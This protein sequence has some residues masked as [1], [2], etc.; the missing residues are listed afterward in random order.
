VKI[1]TRLALALA[2]LVFLGCSEP[3]GPTLYPVSGKVLM[4]GA[5]ATGGTVSFRHEDG[6]HQPAGVIKPDGSYSLK[7]GHREGAP[8]GHYRVVVFV[9]EPPSKT[10]NGYSGLPRIIVNEE[11]QNPSSTPLKAEIKADPS[12]QQYDF[13]VT[14]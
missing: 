8:P 5:P 10:G 2:M 12:P 9:T 4:N 11:F 3:P 1:V 13:E 14:S 7:S 6:L